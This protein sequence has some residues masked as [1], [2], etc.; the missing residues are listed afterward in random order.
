MTTP[1]I[2]SSLVSRMPGSHRLPASG[3]PGYWLCSSCGLPGLWWGRVLAWPA[4][5]VGRPSYK[6]TVDGKDGSLVCR[7]VVVVGRGGPMR[8]TP[9]PRHEGHPPP[10]ESAPE[11]GW[12]P[13]FHFDFYVVI[14]HFLLVWA[15]S[16]TLNAVHAFPSKYCDVLHSSARHLGYWD[17]V[18]TDSSQTN[19]QHVE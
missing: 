2:G 16:L 3:T 6:L 5:G 19:L 17:H 14:Q 13:R 10:F 18:G 11:T 8:R 12:E 9:V 1:N 7:R 15:G 4:S